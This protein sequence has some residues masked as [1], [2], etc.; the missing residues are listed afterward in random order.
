MIKHLAVVMDGNRRW[1]KKNKL[2]YQ[3]GYTDGGFGA[4]KKTVQFCLDKEIRHLSLYTFSLENFSRPEHEKQL[5]FNAIVQEGNKYGEKFKDQGVRIKFIGDRKKFPEKVIPTIKYLEDITSHNQKLEL[6]ILF[7]YGARQEIVC[8]IKELYHKVKQGLLKEEHISEE[9]L[10][11][12]LWTS[13]TPSPELII[14][15][16][17]TK[18]LSNFLLYQSAYSELCFLD[19]LWPEIEVS[20]LENA[21]SSFL[22]T[23]R[24]YGV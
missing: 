23:K 15:T 18:R 14:R 24:N 9:S 4:V 13:G 8:G 1:A 11:K 21:V 6:N 17:G 5:L 3:L 19:C 20:D 10:E 12:C 16:S 22:G 2:N 7:C